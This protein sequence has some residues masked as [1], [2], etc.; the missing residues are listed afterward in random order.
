MSEAAAAPVASTPTPAAAPTSSAKSHDYG[1]GTLTDRIM[2]N[3]GDDFD[4]GVQYDTP[5]GSAETSIDPEDFDS[6]DDE[7]GEPTKPE[8]PA[9]KKKDAEKDKPKAPVVPKDE[10]SEEPR[11]AKSIL[12]D[13]K[14]T[15]D[16]P[17]SVKDLPEDRFVKVKVDGEERVLPLREMA[18]GYI[19][20]QTMDRGL[21][22][23]KQATADA[24]RIAQ[25]HIQ[26]RTKLRA[27]VDAFLSN[28]ERMFTYLMERDPD[29]LLRLGERI[30]NQWGEW[31][32]N[33]E[34][35]QRHNYQ[36][37]Q[38]QIEAERKRVAQERQQWELERTKREAS[39]R[40]RQTWEPVWKESLKEA[41]FPK[42]TPEFQRIVKALVSVAQ[43]DGGG[44][45]TTE[46]F[47][48]CVA[49]AAQIT[50]AE[51]VASR[52]PP[53]QNPPGDRTATP[54]RPPR[55]EKKW[56]GMSHAQKFRD[57][58]WILRRR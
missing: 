46:A 32:K 24:E 30:G 7:G 41:G 48:A 26:E 11:A 28:D 33:P 12:P 38:R 14:G 22:A 45:V 23:A 47:K 4:L 25:T 10:A 19:R 35:L 5:A 58:D 1:A 6:D 40:S 43:E 29:V 18:D 50:G 55:G 16:A 53:A 51:T 13:D 39:E 36:R 56:E 44:R 42:V 37:Q 52:K 54:A 21:S 31:Q 27:D 15:E 49:K 3:I 2:S 9:P 57:P 17:Y 20:K 8:T 34:A